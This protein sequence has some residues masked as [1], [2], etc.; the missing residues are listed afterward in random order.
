M[1]FKDVFAFQK[2]FNNIQNQKLPLRLAY[3]FTKLNDII[4]N[5]LCFYQSEFEK[6]L[7][8]YAER[9]SEGKYIE[10]EAKNGIIIKEEFLEECHREIANLQNFEFSIDGIFFTLDE[11]EFLTITPTELK[12][13]Y[14]L[15]KE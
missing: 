2:L 5:E 7:D 3:K 8:S 9:D 13:L 4:S 6:I 15:I 11:L 12:C 10:N 14:T 1:K